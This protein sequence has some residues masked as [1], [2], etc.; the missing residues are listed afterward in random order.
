M[1]LRLR[2]WSDPARGQPRPYRPFAKPGSSL[3]GRSLQDDRRKIHDSLRLLPSSFSSCSPWFVPPFSRLDPPFSRRTTNAAT[4]SN[5]R[6]HSVVAQMSTAA[7]APQHP[8]KANSGVI[9]LPSFDRNTPSRHV[10]AKNADRE[11][12]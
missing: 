4:S 3:R 10:Y 12:F 7:P 8:L 6:K 11:V 1:F 5:H 9:P 2:T